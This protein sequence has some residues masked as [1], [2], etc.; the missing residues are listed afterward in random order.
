MTK[1]DSK[2]TV[3]KPMYQQ[4]D[5][6]CHIHQRPDMYVGS[7]LPQSHSGGEWIWKEE[8]QSM[9]WV[10][11]PF[12]SEG[13][14]RIYVEPL[15]NVIDNVWRSREEGFVCK[16]I[17]VDVCS[18]TGQCT[19]WNDGRGIPIEKQ[20][21]SDVYTPEFI[22]GRL[23]TSS[24]YNDEEERFSSGRNG[25]GI[26]LTN[27]FSKQF[28]IELGD[29]HQQKVYSQTW[30]GHMRQ[31]SPPLIKSKKLS[32][33]YTKLTFLPDLSLFGVTSLDSLFMGFIAKVVLDMAMTTQLPV[34]WNQKK[35]VFKHLREYCVLYPH[36]REKTQSQKSCM[37]E[38]SCPQSREKETMTIVLLPASSSNGYS[39][40][41][42]NGIYTKDGGVHQQITE[43]QTLLPLVQKLQ[44]QYKQ[45]NSTHLSTKEIKPYI[46]FFVFCSLINPTFTSQN[47]TKLVSPTPQCSPLD[48]RQIHTLLSKWSFLQH[49]ETWLKMKE[50][51]TL[52][53]T[54]KKTRQ[55]FQ[56][57]EGL[58]HAN[59]ANTKSRHEC[60]LILC[61]GLSAKTYAVM[62]MDIGCFGKKGRDYFGVFALKGKILNCR[63]ASSDTISQNKEIVHLIQALNLKHHVDYT[64]DEHFQSLSYGRVLII[65]DA[66]VDG[67][68]ITSL[69]VNLFAVLFPSLLQRPFL[70]WML[71]PIA[72]ISYSSHTLTFWNDIDYQRHMERSSSLSSTY[73]I[74]YYKGLGTSSDTEVKETF[75]QKVVQ[76]VKDAKAD[77][78]L[79]LVFS[80]HTSQ[81]RKQWLETFSSQ[82]YRVPENE[83]PIS[84][85]LDQ[86]HLRFSLDDCRR[87][88]PHVFDGLKL[89]Q[90]KILYAVFRK[91]LLPSNKSMK[92]AQ[93]AG[94]VAEVSNYHHGEQCLYDTITR[95]A[96][97]FVGSQNIPLLQKD[98]QFGSRLHLGKDA[99][100][101]RY[102]F[103]KMHNYTRL[104]FPQEDDDLLPYTLDDGE[105]VE[106][107]YYLPILPLFFLNGC[108]TGIGS[109]WSCTM[110][111]FQ[112]KEVM[113]KV[114]NYIHHQP[115]SFSSMVPF[116]CGFRGKIE[117]LSPSRFQCQGIVRPIQEEEEGGKRKKKK[118]S[119]S[120]HGH[121]HTHEIIE[122]PIDM[123]IDKYKEYLEIWTEE[124]KILGFQNY[125]TPHQPHFCFTPAPGFEPTLSSMKLCSDLSL[126]NMVVLTENHQIQ[127][128]DTLDDMFQLY[129][130]QRL[131]LY[132]SRRQSLLQH[133]KQV[134]E[135]QEFFCMFFQDVH[136]R[137]LLLFDRQETEIL[138][139]MSH[140]YDSF[141]QT[142]VSLQKENLFKKVLQLPIRTFTKS[143]LE[144]HQQ[145]WKQAQQ[146][147]HVYQTITPQELWKSDLEPLRQLSFFSE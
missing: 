121:G 21:S 89:S 44:K 24:N 65:T 141:F 50:S 94:Y 27:V 74:K 36:D 134:M 76:F 75:G 68:H 143:S 56:R 105:K 23:L 38:W 39:V 81:E 78:H 126:T 14:H 43:K 135:T 85:F 54:E 8:E 12:Y 79:H 100:N 77:Q 97:D 136:Q 28:D 116:Y 87:N 103:T 13:L 107:D 127:K 80:K 129:A 138:N 40:S 132:E 58:D 104:L 117:T 35:Y 82:E 147:V 48:S 53:K 2:E 106:P 109:G 145:K 128:F 3:R 51:L 118:S 70:Y 31:C 125:S 37:M 18:Q 49:I 96:Q 61:E 55:A 102:I 123:S 26:K 137:H 45:Y 32:S 59:K 5:P 46:C 10:P 73:T 29:V 11:D 99:A 113:E 42:V 108:K 119:S 90:R 6:I 101:G 25:I 72:K 57:I 120:R 110:P 17:V 15:S 122:L 62:G 93:L 111:M 131:K 52:K 47:K 112:P 16:K 4:L 22:F 71:T 142:H 130:N 124:K 146:K 63:N 84:T 7:L 98:G 33:S 64:K 30:V 69:L 144:H 140:R 41:F 115:V 95:M 114:W 60:T 1:K 139:D 19:V 9:A 66:D 20:P 67:L 83:Y 133:W 34:Y 86:D 91:P 88:L 92:V